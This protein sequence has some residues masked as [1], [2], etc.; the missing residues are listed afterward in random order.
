MIRFAFSS[1]DTESGY[2]YL[3][4]YNGTSISAPLI[5]TYHGTA[6]PGTVT[7]SN[8]SGALTFNFTSDGSITKAGWSAAIS[9]YSSSI[10]PVAE[11]TVTSTSPATNSTVTFTDQSTNIPTAWTWNFSPNTILF[12]NGTTA[13]SQAPQVQFSSQGQYTVSLTVSNSYGSD[14]EV[15][16]NYINVIPYVYCIPAYTTGSGSGDYITLV[17]LGTINNATGASASPYYTYYSNLSTN[18]TPGSINTITLSPGTYTSGNNISVWIDYNQNGVFETTEKLGNVV[19]PATPATSTISF[20]V[21]AEATSGTTRMRVRE[22]YNNSS[23]DACSS[24][25]YGETEDYNVNI[26]SLAKNLSLT[27]YL[28]GL[29]AGNGSMRKAQNAGGDQFPGTTADQITIEL[30]NTAN[31]ATIA[32]TASNVN[33]STSGVATVSIPPGISGSFYVTVKHRNSITIT[34]ASPVSFSGSSVN[35]NYDAASKAYGSNMQLMVD[36]RWVIF[37]GDVNGDG[38]VDTG[39][40]TPVDNLASLYTSGYIPEDSNGDGVIDTGDMTVIDNNSL[41]YVTT[42]TP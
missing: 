38:Q 23:F 28:E 1:F 36:G 14:S 24:Y 39:D 37:G 19:A 5:G 21:P 42:I 34:T 32:H 17:Q 30:H 40:M 18:L 22:V 12:M 29:Y 11:F 41:N 9:C 3:K 35:Y 6:G 15:K 26:Q 2:D 31:Y 4:I 27:L 8:A 13:N 7:A 33:L 20:T 16:T 10:P 25:T